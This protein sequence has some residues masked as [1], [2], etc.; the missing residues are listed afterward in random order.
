ME[1]QSKKQDDEG[2][3]FPLFAWDERLIDPQ[4]EHKAVAVVAACYG[5]SMNWAQKNYVDPYVPRD[6]VEWCD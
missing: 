1:K 3:R 5:I 4:Q 6:F 2:S